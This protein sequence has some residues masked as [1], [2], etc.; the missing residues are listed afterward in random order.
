MPEAAVELVE[1]AAEAGRTAVLIAVDGTVAGCLV[2][3]DELKESAP[4]AVAQLRRRLDNIASDTR[5]P[6]DD[7]LKLRSQVE[8]HEIAKHDSSRDCSLFCLSSMYFTRLG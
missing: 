3:S 5:Y 1:A 8:A 4:A 7:V 2:V 6:R